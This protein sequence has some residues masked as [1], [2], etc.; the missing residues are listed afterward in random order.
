ALERRG[1][2]SNRARELGVATIAALLPARACGTKIARQMFAPFRWHRA[3]RTR[4]DELAELRDDLLT[5]RGLRA[6][7]RRR[8]H[9]A[10]QLARERRD[11][12]QQRAQRVGL[13][14]EIG[15]A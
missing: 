3:K 11:V 2:G 7:A 13:R 6:L 10:A 4:P 14:D 15:A 1:R 8:L 9:V 12:A 5:D